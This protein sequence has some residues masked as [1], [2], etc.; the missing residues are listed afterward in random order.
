[1]GPSGFELTSFRLDLL[2]MPALE[3]ADAQQEWPVWGTLGIVGGDCL[4]GELALQ[5]IAV[6][7]RIRQVDDGDI[8]HDLSR[9]DRI[10]YIAN[11]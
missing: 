8:T 11:P 3:D 9:Q 4:E 7:E 6:P 5:S 10:P 1:L 2:V